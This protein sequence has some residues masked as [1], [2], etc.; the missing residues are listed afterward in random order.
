M[1]FRITIVITVPF[2]QSRCFNQIDAVVH[3]VHTIWSIN[4]LCSDELG[5]K[6]PVIFIVVTASVSAVNTR[7]TCSLPSFSIALHACTGAPSARVCASPIGATHTQLI[8]KA[9]R[10]QT[11]D[12]FGVARHSRARVLFGPVQRP[13]IMEHSRDVGPTKNTSTLS[14]SRMTMHPAVQT[15]RSKWYIHAPDE[16]PT[17]SLCDLNNGF[18]SMYL[19]SCVCNVCT[20]V[21]PVDWLEISIN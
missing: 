20:N 14:P 3:C 9:L 16:S 1:H 13:W 7:R 2:D 4:P 8:A 5:V 19:D 6:P 15:Q 18:V 21:L 10:W 17:T 11:I 12:Q